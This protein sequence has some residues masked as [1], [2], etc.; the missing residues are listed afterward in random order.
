[1]RNSLWIH[2]AIVAATCRT[3]AFASCPSRSADAKIF[4]RCTPPLCALN[5]ERSRPRSTT[6]RW[7]P[8]GVGLPVCLRAWGTPS[9]YSRAVVQARRCDPTAVA[10]RGDRQA[11][12]SEEPV[13]RYALRTLHASRP[14]VPQCGAGSSTDATLKS[15]PTRSATSQS[16]AC[17]R[18][19]PTSVAF[20][21]QFV[22]RAH[23]AGTCRA[24][25]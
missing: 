22:H 2:G 17:M 10:S 16:R 19:F 14:P 13:R 20:G 1:M 11:Q 18:G 12:E 15:S 9:P 24:M 8:I 25:P 21:I 23:T 6:Y 3:R 7:G 4:K 5:P